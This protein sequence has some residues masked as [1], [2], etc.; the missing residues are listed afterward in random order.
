MCS[1]ENHKDCNNENQIKEILPNTIEEISKFAGERK[2]K[3]I[4]I[5]RIQL[6]I[7]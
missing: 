2:K 4:K 1:L 3:I 6:G 7:E 5:F